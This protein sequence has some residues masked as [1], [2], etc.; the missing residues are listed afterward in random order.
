[1]YRVIKIRKPAHQNS[2][3]FTREV[4]WQSEDPFKCLNLAIQRVLAE[5]ECGYKDLWIEP[6]W[7]EGFGPDRQL[8]YCEIYPYNKSSENYYEI[9]S[10]Q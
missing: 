9:N 2:G 1:M 3:E 10:D 8:Y 6:C 5:T 7:D 4:I